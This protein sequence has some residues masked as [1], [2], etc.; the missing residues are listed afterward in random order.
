[1]ELDHVLIAVAE[2]GAAASE[3]ETRHGLVSIEGGRH[4][5]W[6]TANRIVP[7]GETYLELIAVVDE[8]EAAE[9]SFGRWVLEAHPD[10]ATPLGWAVR[11]DELDLVAQRLGLTVRTGSRLAPDGE[12]LRWRSAGIERAAVEPSLPF[13]IDWDPDSPLP[14]RTA[15]T[16]TVGL[17]KI[18]RLVLD[19]DAD[20]LAGWLGDHELPIVVC[21]GT[22][23]LASIVLAGPASEIV[24][25]A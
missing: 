14:G 2:L 3:L 20:R 23:A 13:F 5:G 11:T 6:G 8:A 25:E 12:L 10:L 21:E 7:L 18:A 16:H 9:S 4:P 15:V 17:V 19:G 24:L 1:L 22:P